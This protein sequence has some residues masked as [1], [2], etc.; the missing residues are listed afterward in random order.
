MLIHLKSLIEYKELLINFAVKELKIK[1]KNSILGFFWSLLNPILS[2]LVFTV[3]FSIFF[4]SNIPNFPIFILAGLLPWNF[5]NAT[6]VGSAVSI[7]S[8][9]GLIKK[10]YFPRELLPVSIAL[11]NMFNFFLELLVFLLFLVITGIFAPQYFAVFKYMPYLLILLPILFLFS[12]GFGLLIAALNVYFRDIQHIIG[13]LLMV[14]FYA[15]PI[16]YPMEYVPAK[17]APAYMLNPL[18]SIVLSFKN[19][20]YWMKAPQLNWI[21]Y[22]SVAAILTFAFGYI[23]FLR[24]APDFAEEL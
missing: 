2:M 8:N 9:A 12:V 23:I 4:K 19:A 14:L 15:S 6:V 13:I 11:A 1:Y 5:F 22:S 24:L 3:V 17:Y 20:L 21:A 16:I 7:I 18:V 10:V